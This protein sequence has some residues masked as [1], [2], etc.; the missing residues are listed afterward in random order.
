MADTA[1]VDIEGDIFGTDVDRDGG[2]VE[3]STLLNAWAWLYPRGWI[4]L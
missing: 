2:V 3:A 1:S 4:L